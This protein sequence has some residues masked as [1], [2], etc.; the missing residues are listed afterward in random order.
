MIKQSNPAISHL[1]QMP[2]NKKQFTPKR[3]ILLLLANISSS[4]LI[5]KIGIPSV[6][7]NIG[8]NQKKLSF[9]RSEWSNSNNF[10]LAT[11]RISKILR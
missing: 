8:L 11:M 1:L 10:M 4:Q 7:E 2:M 6:A 3:G 9:C 5:Y